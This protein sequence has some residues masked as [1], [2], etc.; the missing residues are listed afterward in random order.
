MIPMYQRYLGT[1]RDATEF[2]WTYGPTAGGFP[3]R[4]ERASTTVVERQGALV[5]RNV[6]GVLLVAGLTGA[7]W[8]GAR[9]PDASPTERIDLTP[10]SVT[11]VPGDSLVFNAVRRM[12]DG[13]TVEVPVTFTAAGGEITAAGVFTAGNE[14]GIYP[15]VATA[16][17]E[18]LADTSV[19]MVTAGG[20]RTYGTRFLDDEAP[21]SEEG[22]WIGGGTM[23]LDW[24]DIS[25][26]GGLAVGH[27]VGASYT[28]A[29]AI[30][31]AP[32]SPDQMA[33]ATVHSVAPNDACYQEVELRLRS[34]IA[35]HGNTGYEVAY[36]LSVSPNA[37]LIIVRWNGAL[38]DFTYLL[39]ERGSRFGAGDGDVV[40]ASVIGN[41]ITAYKNGVEMGRAVD[42]TYAAGSPGMGFNLENA[43]DGCRGTNGNYG[44]TDFAAAEV[45]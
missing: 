10:T 39:D 33:S 11:V 7:C 16:A 45:R 1:C 20:A 2:F 5:D 38:G 34:A 18:A 44:F 24:S 8:D 21:I 35:P 31:V 42:T 12:R 9:A 22:R 17:G 43:P 32:W 25:T 40:S 19:V 4:P 26:S 13:S 15:V 14:P 36:K 6:F 30:L 37:Y 27:Q 23:G 41:V 29:T 3:D 28:D